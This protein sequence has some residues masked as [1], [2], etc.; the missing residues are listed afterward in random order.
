LRTLSGI[1]NGGPTLIRKKKTWVIQG[2][3]LEMGAGM[4]YLVIIREDDS[5]REKGSFKRMGK[6]NN[7]FTSPFKR[8]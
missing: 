4:R 1:S 3:G 6:K 8:D 5:N 2:Q 7:I